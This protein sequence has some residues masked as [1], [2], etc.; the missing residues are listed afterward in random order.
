MILKMLYFMNISLNLKKYIFKQKL[1]FI[2]KII[3]SYSIHAMLKK[4]RLK[5]KYSKI[6]F[7]F[8]A[9]YF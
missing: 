1:I 4:N 5:Y 8:N 7:R 6:I 9:N 2:E 3:T